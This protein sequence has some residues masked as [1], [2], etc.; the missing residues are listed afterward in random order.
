[1]WKVSVNA[2]KQSVLQLYCRM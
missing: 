2:V 1:M